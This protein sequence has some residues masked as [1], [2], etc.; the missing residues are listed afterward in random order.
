[1]RKFFTIKT[2]RRFERGFS[3]TEVLVG[4]TLLTVSMMATGTVFMNTSQMTKTTRLIEAANLL[5][6]QVLKQQMR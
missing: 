5:T 2:A 3:V 4:I 6:E 1:M